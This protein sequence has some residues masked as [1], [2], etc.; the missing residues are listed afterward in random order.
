MGKECV[1]H[2][3]GEVHGILSFAIEPIY[4]EDRAI[5][6]SQLNVLVEGDPSISV[7]VKSFEEKLGHLRRR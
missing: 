5:L 4:G 2:G 6:L 7:E 1:M 3:N